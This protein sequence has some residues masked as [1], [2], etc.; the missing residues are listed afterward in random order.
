MVRYEIFFSRRTS[1]IIEAAGFYEKDNCLYFYNDENDNI[2]I[3]SV[4]NFD[5]MVIK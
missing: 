4:F 3:V 1:K 5:Y 2:F